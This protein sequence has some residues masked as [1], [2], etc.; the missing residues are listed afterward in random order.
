MIFCEYL[1]TDGNSCIDLGMKCKSSLKIKLGFK[2]TSITGYAIIGSKTWISETDA[3]R[4][5]NYNNSAYLD[6]GSGVG[7]ARIIGGRIALNTQYNLEIGNRYVKDINT[8]SYLCQGS[9]VTDFEKPYNL[10]LCGDNA[11]CKGYFYFVQVYDSDTLVF[12]GYPAVDDDGHAGLYD[13]ISASFF[14]NIGSSDF[15]AGP[16][17]GAYDAVGSIVSSLENATQL[18]TNSKTDDGTDIVGCAPW[19]NYQNS[20]AS[21]VYLNGNSYIGFGMDAPDL[22]VDNRDNAMWNNW[23]EYGTL[24]GVRFLRVR[25]SGYA[26][27]NVQYDEYKLT[28]DVLMF[29]TGDICLYMA[30]IPTSNNTGDY[31]LGDQTY[32]A[33]TT[34]NRWVTFYKTDTGFKV[35]YEPISFVQYLTKYLIRNE[36]T[37]YTIVD[38]ALSELTGELTAELF[39]TSGVDAVPDGALLMTLS[40]PEV[41]CWTN[42]DT[43]PVL[44][45]TVQGVPTGAHGVIS[46]E[47]PVGHSS[48]YGISS[49]VATASDG[50]TF[51]LSF[52]GG[53]WMAYTDST[54][55]V[56]DI[57]MTAAELMA[58]PS[59]AWSSVINSAQYMQLK[60]TLEGVETVTQVVFN[61]N[62]DSPTS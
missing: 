7:G 45:A 8:E 53:A 23:K 42:E 6:W 50:A 38:C 57:G 43:V 55:S 18:R 47:I 51:L 59:T 32:T 41:L 54:W 35:K 19:F 29:E 3:F 61:F 40:A 27:Y 60:A 12:D 34:D 52:D 30:D 44:A 1:Y 9:A 28:Y 33:P 16:L 48:I 37:L 13:M 15:V 17:Y 4:F 56:S 10:T 36:C 24:N 39:Q 11:D 62:N 46:D 20:A 2:M 25:W 31:K 14:A 22:K 26:N 21:K 5:F 49:V 58:I